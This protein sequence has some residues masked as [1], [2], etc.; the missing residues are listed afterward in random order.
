MKQRTIFFSFSLLLFGG[1][2]AAQDYTCYRERIN[3]AK[4][5][6]NSCE[7]RKAA[8]WIESIRTD[9][10]LLPEVN[11]IKS[12]SEKISA[13]LGDNCDNDGD[14]VLNRNDKC[15]NNAGPKNNN[16]CPVA[17]SDYDGF[18]DNVDAC[19]DKYSTTNRG[20]PEGPKPMSLFDRFDDNRNG[21]PLNSFSK[22]SAGKLSLA[23]TLYFREVV[24]Q[25]DIDCS[26]DFTCSVQANWMT[27]R[28]GYCG[29][30]FATGDTSFYYFVISTAGEYAVRYYTPS[31][32]FEHVIEWTESN[33]IKE[34][35]A[36]NIGIK[37]TDD[38]MV[39][40]IN[41]RAQD[42]IPF[43][44]ARGSRFGFCVS[45]GGSKLVEFDN[46]DL[47]GFSK[48]A[49]NYTPASNKYAFTDY[50]F[51]NENS[52]PLREDT[53]KKMFIADN[54][55]VITS[56]NSKYGY[57]LLKYY[58]IDISRDFTCYAELSVIKTTGYGM[59]ITFCDG[60]DR[61]FTFL[62]SDYS[63]YIVSKLEKDTWDPIVTWTNF[64]AGYNKTRNK[65]LIKKRG[66]N[67]SF[68]INGKLMNTVP[69]ISG[70]G[71]SFGLRMEGN[72]TVHFDNFM[73]S[74]ERLA[75]K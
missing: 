52:W 42:T 68:Y 8:R 49:S 26:R 72:Q 36:N 69:F 37:K 60:S 51:N 59:G 5:A 20:C 62:L 14:G 53:S 6:Y 47:Q 21:W 31:I 64:T 18:A 23:D 10:C 28:D 40:Y 19:P 9:Q 35:V 71:N 55:L 11:E 54:K 67:I 39:F 27:D 48:P 29:L 44:D 24:K 7:Y 1:S 43:S 4:A 17:D 41:G 30:V 32:V 15:P 38:F 34:G 16:G 2:L 56:N 66:N 46:F 3:K 25:S 61:S 65:L 74:G 70:G 45:G 63:T 13:G 58:P 22:I 12:L 75:T 73:L 50:F 57:N 33:D